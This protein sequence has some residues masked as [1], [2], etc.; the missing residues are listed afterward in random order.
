MSGNSRRFSGTIE[1]PR[2]T[3]SVVDM[4]DT[5]FPSRTT[6]PSDGVT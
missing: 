1:T 5:T 6:S 3:T 4:P 2:R